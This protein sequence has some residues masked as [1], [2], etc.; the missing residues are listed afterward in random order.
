MIARFFSVVAVSALA[1][2]TPSGA[3]ELAP[4]RQPAAVTEAAEPP[5]PPPAAPGASED[6]LRDPRCPAGWVCDYAAFAADPRPKVTEIRVQKQAHLLHLVADKTIVRSYTIAIG[7]GGLGHKYYEGDKVTPI[8]SY[9][10][11]GRYPSRWHTYLAIDYPNAEDKARH[12][13]AVE[14]GEIPEGR[15]PG[16]AIAIHGHRKDQPPRMHKLVDW[17]LGCVSLDNDE[18][19]E[20]AGVV[21][22]GTK[23]VIER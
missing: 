18:I 16:S 22:V 3:Q 4:E 8:G 14:R 17:T 15:G 11:T 5:A 2:C 20:V 9:T 7:P 13:A 23:V 10:I 21:T 12:A 1:A 19:D 6:A